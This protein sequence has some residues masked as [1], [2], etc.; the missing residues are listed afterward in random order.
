MN[1]GMGLHLIIRVIP[2]ADGAVS[3]DLPIGGRNVFD[4]TATMGRDTGLFEAGVGVVIGKATVGFV[5]LSVVDC[6][7]GSS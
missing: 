5:V 6:V 2:L 7:F 1:T 3:K 4:E